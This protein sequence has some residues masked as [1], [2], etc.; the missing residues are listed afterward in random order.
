MNALQ[1]RYSAEIERAI[2]ESRQMAQMRE[3]VTVEATWARN[4]AN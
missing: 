3:R 4:P 1:T 2:A